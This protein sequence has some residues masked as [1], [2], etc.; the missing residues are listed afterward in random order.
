MKILY[1]TT[2]SGTMGFFPEHIRMLQ[3]AGHT[4]ELAANLT[5]PLPQRVMVL[6]CRTHH[7]DFSRNPVSPDN[8][9]A[10]RQIQKLMEEGKYDIVHTHTPNASMVLRLAARKFRKKGM[11]VFYTPFF[12]VRLHLKQG[13]RVQGNSSRIP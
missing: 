8:L 12:Q 10:Y 4:V 3:E 1:V 2:I 11:K 6:N 5:D 7:I 13:Y 9:K